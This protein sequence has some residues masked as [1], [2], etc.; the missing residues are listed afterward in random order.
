MMCVIPHGSPTNR[1][2]TSLLLKRGF[3]SI[4]AA[5]S[6]LYSVRDDAWSYFL[7]RNGSRAG[8]LRKSARLIDEEKL[9]TGV[10]MK[11][12]L[13]LRRKLALWFS[14]VKYCRPAAILVNWDLTMRREHLASSRSVAELEMSCDIV[15]SG[16]SS[17]LNCMMTLLT[18]LTSPPKSVGDP[19]E[20]LRVED[21][22]NIASKEYPTNAVSSKQISLR[23]YPTSSRDA[24][25]LLEAALSD[26]S[27][28]EIDAATAPGP[29][30]VT[31]VTAA[32]DAGK[33]IPAIRITQSTMRSM[34]RFPSSTSLK[35]GE[36]LT[37]SSP[38]NSY[39]AIP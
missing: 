6:R 32:G 20:S 26:D 7:G 35:I 23:L 14:V 16:S 27:P 25:A 10:L 39:R 19:D 22:E 38:P 1:T 3:S 13:E 34:I 15:V 28:L 30:V 33:R 9:W 37:M 4:T 36:S 5:A 31:L 8:L 12:K 2:F 11:S 29:V 21:R 17:E 18:V 24:T